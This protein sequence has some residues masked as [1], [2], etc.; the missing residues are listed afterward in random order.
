MARHSKSWSGCT[1]RVMCAL[2]W[3][4]TASIAQAVTSAPPPQSVTVWVDH[5]TF[6][7]WSSGDI[8]AVATTL[9][10]TR[11]DSVEL[12]A[13]GPEAFR[14]LLSAAARL[15]DLPL[16]LQ[17][18][19]SSAP[20]CANVPATTAVAQRASASGVGE[21]AVARYWLQVMP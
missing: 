16:Q 7:D 20:A 13:C 2:L 10:A 18:L 1:P 5:Y 21:A 4:L 12:V 8:D 9:R 17:V 14:A 11:P 3:G 19:S 6:D 15:N